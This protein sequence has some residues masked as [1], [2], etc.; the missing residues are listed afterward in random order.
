MSDINW[1]TV[2]IAIGGSAVPA[3]QVLAVLG[4]AFVVAM[5][6]TIVVAIAATTVKRERG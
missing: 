6:V 5:V 3:W 2:E 4:G 1:D